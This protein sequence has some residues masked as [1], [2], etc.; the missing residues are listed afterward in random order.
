MV[1]GGKGSFEVKV[2]QDYVLLAG[3]GVLHT[4]AKVGY[5]TGAGSARPDSFLF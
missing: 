3:V 2:A 4:Q 1:H 5:R